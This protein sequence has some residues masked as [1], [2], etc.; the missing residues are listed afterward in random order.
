MKNESI[1]NQHHHCQ[2]FGYKISSFTTLFNKKKQ[3]LGSKIINLGQTLAGRTE[4][5]C[6]PPKMRFFCFFLDYIHQNTLKKR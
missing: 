3:I 6:N 2:Y 1:T 4:N 5:G